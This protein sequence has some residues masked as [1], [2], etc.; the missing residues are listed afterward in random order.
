MLYLQHGGGRFDGPVRDIGED[1]H[2]FFVGAS[3]PEQVWVSVSEFSPNLFH[4]SDALSCELASVV[5]P[6]LAFRRWP[7]KLEIPIMGA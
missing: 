4:P 3:A 5:L 2:V 1:L 7:T 6:K